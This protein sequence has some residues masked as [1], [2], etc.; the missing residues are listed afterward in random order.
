MIIDAPVWRNADLVRIIPITRGDLNQAIARCGFRPEY[1]PKPGK[2]RW[3]SWRDVVAVAAAQ[4]L[5]KIGFG[6]AVA[7]GLVQNHLLPFLRDAIKTP[8]DCDG[9]IWLVS[10][11]G[12][13]RAEDTSCEFLCQSDG[14]EALIAPSENARI[15]VNVGRIAA[16][17]LHDLQATETANVM[18]REFQAP[19]T[20]N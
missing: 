9:M 12:D 14:I 4:D 19:V 6:P 8:E 15:V 1:K 17:V 11:S 18:L 10:L 13:Y 5:R 2:D 3:Y 16:R 7:F 20:L